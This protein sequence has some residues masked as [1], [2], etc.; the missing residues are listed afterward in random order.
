MKA[1]N[2]YLQVASGTHHTDLDDS[3]TNDKGQVINFFEA[4]MSG[5][6]IVVCHKLKLARTTGFFDT[7]DLE[8]VKDYC[9]FF[10]NGELKLRYEI[11]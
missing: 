9:P 3:I 2:F 10:I 7:A 1:S 11:D 6:I 4:D 8:D 5:E